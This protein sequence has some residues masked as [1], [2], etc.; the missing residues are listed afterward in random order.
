MEDLTGKNRERS[1]Q[2]SQDI[3]YLKTSVL[4]QE[5]KCK[6]QLL[7][8]RKGS[9]PKMADPG[10]SCQ[11][12]FPH[13]GHFLL[14]QQTCSFSRFISNSRNVKVPRE[15]RIQKSLFKKFDRAKE[16]SAGSKHGGPYTPDTDYRLQWSYQT[17]HSLCLVIPKNVDLGS[18]A[19]L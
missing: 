3:F 17:R 18:K 12:N 13:C 11:E 16:T 10:A 9:P 6:S 19:Q 8:K 4:C 14:S 1:K 7:F 5:C 15:V 2:R